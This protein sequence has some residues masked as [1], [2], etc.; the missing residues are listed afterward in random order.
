MNVNAEKYISLSEP[1][2]VTA[3]I[4]G[5]SRLDPSFYPELM[6]VGP[7][8]TSGIPRF[9]DEVICTYA[10]LDRLIA[11]CGLSKSEMYTVQ[12]LMRG[13]SVT[14]IAEMN[15]IKHPTVSVWLRRAVQ[16][17]CKANT[18]RWDSTYLST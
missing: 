10:D 5:R 4:S 17:I 3:L 14:D 12:K 13:Y 6:P 7:T 15:N 1:R 2:V 8:E 18:L 9:D 16:K 11:E